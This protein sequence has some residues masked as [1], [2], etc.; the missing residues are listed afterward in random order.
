MIFDPVT[1]SLYDSKGRFL[2]VLDCPQKM[3]WDD[4]DKTDSDGVRS[5]SSCNDQVVSLQHYSDEKVRRL[6]KR[7]PTLCVRIEADW[8]NVIVLHRGSDQWELKYGSVHGLTPPSVETSRRPLEQEIRIKTARSLEQMNVGVREGFWPLIESV[9]DP[10]R[11]PCYQH[12]CIYQRKDDGSVTLGGNPWRAPTSRDENWEEIGEFRFYQYRHQ[13]PIAA[14]LV[15]KDLP[16]LTRVIL[17]DPIDDLP[18]ETHHGVSRATDLPAIW[19][20]SRF[21]IL[22]TEDDVIP[23]VG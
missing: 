12:V 20:G 10:S 22:W 7:L 9:P 13:L 17:E 8:P 14:Y 21:Q 2:K 5:C 6:L 16:P 1:S 23:C 11:S 19:T 18:G 15:P 4:L 3:R